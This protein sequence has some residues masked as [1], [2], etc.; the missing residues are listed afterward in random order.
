MR[1]GIALITQTTLPSEPESRPVL[2]ENVFI[3]A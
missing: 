2:N 1:Q 3:S